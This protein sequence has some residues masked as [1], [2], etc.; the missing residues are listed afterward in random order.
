M[1][2]LAGTSGYA[3]KEWKGAFYPKEMKDEGMLGYY[4]AKFPTVEINN[5]FYR[6]PKESVLLDWAAQVPEPFTFAIK[7]SQRIT[8]HA[9]L[10]PE[11]GDA[12]E[13]LLRNVRSLGSRLGPVLFQLPPNLKKDLLRLRVF[14]DLLPQSGRFTFEFRHASWFDEEVFDVLRARDMALC[15]TDQ[16]EFASPVV[17]TASWGYARL[18]KLDYDLAALASWA[19]KLEAQ[20][21]TDGYVFFKHD[22]GVGSGPPAVDAFTRACEA[23]S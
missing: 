6:L 20:S 13:F 4:S 10:K 17:A 9:R 16:P 3:F 18:H 21:W 8:H 7:A 1:K 2:L 22:E 19:E 15:I 5:T 12:V 11:C 14:L 23:R